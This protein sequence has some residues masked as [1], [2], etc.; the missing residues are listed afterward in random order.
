MKTRNMPRAKYY[1]RVSALER[2]EANK[3]SRAMR[4]YSET[5][6]GQHEFQVLDE[7]IKNYA[8]MGNRPSR[9]MG[10]A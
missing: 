9:T 7:R 2:L 6:S 3:K 1:R 4:R 10:G 8:Q 5:P